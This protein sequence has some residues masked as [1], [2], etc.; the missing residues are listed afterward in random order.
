MTA[1]PM[2]T[3]RKEDDCLFH[4]MT[5]AD[6]P[7]IF[8]RQQQ[9]AALSSEFDAFRLYV[10]LHYDHTQVAYW[11]NQFVLR[12]SLRGEA[13]YTAPYETQ[14][15]PA[16]L[17]ALMAHERA[18]GG[19]ELRFL[20]VEKESCRIPGQFGVT[21]RRDLYD[22]VYRADD[23]IH[24]PGRDYAAKRNQIAQFKRKYDWRFAPLTP[25]N[26][27]DCLS[28][29]DRWYEAHNGTMIA[30][31]R[32]AIERMVRCPFAL[33]QCGA[34]LYADGNPV[35]FAVGS[36]PRPQLLDVVA[37]KALPAYIGVYSMIIQA[38]AEYA[39]TLA[40]FEYVNREEDMGLEN[41]RNAKLQLKPAMLI[42]KSLLT[43]PL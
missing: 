7:L 39:Y 11:R 33:G 31:E 34:V 10:W 17:A 35:A 14:D 16:L 24:M 22:Y 4:P 5:D 42:E 20:C 38:F 3:V 13:C 28:V 43:A 8:E 26:A 1:N 27:G 21:P 6:L 40:P 23:L 15:M 9:L 41:L 18:Q 30:D 36:H 29:V 19:R 2:P 12:F 37:E 25:A 32:I